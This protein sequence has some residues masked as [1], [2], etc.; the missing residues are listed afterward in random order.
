MIEAALGF[1]PIEIATIVEEAQAFAFPC[2]AVSA[3]GLL[4][5]IP[6]QLIGLLRCTGMDV[7]NAVQN[8]PDEYYTYIP[9]S[10]RDAV[11]QFGPELSASINYVD[12]VVSSDSSS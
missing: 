8:N 11:E 7:V 1:H 5:M 6:A 2:A 9:L 3:G 10:L 12:H 4:A